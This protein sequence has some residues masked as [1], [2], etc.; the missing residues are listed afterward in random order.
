M[1]VAVAGLGSAAMRGHL[2]ALRALAGEGR[3]SL[4]G[5][6]D[7]DPRRRLV[8][9]R[10]APGL[11]TFASAE[12]MLASIE[13]DLFVIATPPATHASLAALAA[14]HRQHILCEKP[15]GSTPAQVAALA[16]IRHQNPDRALLA[17]YQYRFS[18]PWSL[19]AR[20]LRAAVGEGRRVALSV[21]VQR[22]LTDRHA[23]S[24]WRDDPAMGGGLADHGVHFLALAR[25]LGGPLEVRVGERE[26][27]ERH[28]ELVRAS[29]SL[30]ENLLELSVSYRAPARST[31][32][33]VECGGSVLDWTD[34]SLVL[35]REGRR[36]RPLPVSSLA[37]RTHVD[38][39][40]T[41]MYRD[42]LA[43]VEQPLWRQYRAE[44]LLEVSRNLTVLLAEAGPVL[45]ALEPLQLAA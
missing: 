31:K 20:F 16:E 41:P 34:G 12:E 2:S 17:T 38:S 6:C 22:S 44:E 4:V 45:C 27:D 42:V 14:A 18:H 30:G 13:S 3:A 32:L 25:A 23:L 39:L 36:G 43:G 15:A 21:D 5:A 19:I 11:P 1:R 9:E 7:P 37:D 8:A 29:C 33:T 40:Y 28:R 10:S 24:N 35:E 26:Y